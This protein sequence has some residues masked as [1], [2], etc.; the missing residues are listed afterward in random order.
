MPNF[1]F[2]ELIFIVINKISHLSTI[3]EIRERYFSAICFNV[4][5]KGTICEL[6]NG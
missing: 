6:A 4:N 3:Q 2:A 5:P 1:N